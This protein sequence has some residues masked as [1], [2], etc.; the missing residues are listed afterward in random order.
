MSQSQ[1]ITIGVTGGIA[2]GKTTVT[3]F[4]ANRGIIIVDADLAARMVVEPGKPALNEIENRFGSGILINGYLDRS[5]LRAIIF[6]NPGEREWLEKLLHPLIREQIRLEL[7]EADSPYSML[8]SPLMLETD[9]HELVYRILVV[10]LPEKIQVKR[11]MKRDDMDE[12]QTRK[13]IKSQIPR[14]KRLEW[15]DDV[16]DNS[17]TLKQLRHSLESLH[18]KYLSLI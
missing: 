12:E 14:D 18:Q 8:V 9:Q 10:D 11:A 16:I 17:G 4:F 5:Q 13:I 7:S 6:D 2:S 15:A 3:D 1:M